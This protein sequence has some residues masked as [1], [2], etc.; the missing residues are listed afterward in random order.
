MNFVPVQPVR[1]DVLSL[2]P[3]SVPELT[4]SYLDG[5]RRV[6][7]NVPAFPRRRCPCPSPSQEMVLPILVLTQGQ[8]LSLLFPQGTSPSRPCYAPAPVTTHAVV[9]FLPRNKFLLG[10]KRQDP[11]RSKE[12]LHVLV[13]LVWVLVS[14]LEPCMLFFW[15][16]VVVDDVSQGRGAPR[17]E[18]RQAS[19]IGGRCIR[20]M[21]S[22]SGCGYGCT[23]LTNC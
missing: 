22:G 20:A 6:V 1:F 14:T 11:A 3:S 2:D 17:N 16:V 5:G 19:S 23:V 18:L 10:E 15:F 8:L 4:T 7:T 9:L 13:F 12:A 21:D